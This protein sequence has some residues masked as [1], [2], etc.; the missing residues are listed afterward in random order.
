MVQLE[1]RKPEREVSGMIVHYPA[2]FGDHKGILLV[3]V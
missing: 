1:L 2:L 3:V